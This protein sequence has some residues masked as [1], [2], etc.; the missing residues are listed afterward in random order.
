MDRDPRLR[1]EF[2]KT[3]P[4][5]EKIEILYEDLLVA[6][7]DREVVRHRTIV[8]FVA[9][10]LAIT[11]VA[12]LLFVI[13]SGGQGVDKRQQYELCLSGNRGKGSLQASLKY[14]FMIPEAAQDF[15]FMNP[16]LDCGPNLRGKPATVLAI[17][18]QDKYSTYLWKNKTPP[19]IRHGRVLN[20]PETD[21]GGFATPNRKPN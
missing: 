4:D 11:T 12:V 10:L 3:Q 18:E 9:A 7:R 16:I 15:R 14:R 2:F 19:K 20:L 6:R 5:E 8:S 13:F 21:G 17:I 1:P